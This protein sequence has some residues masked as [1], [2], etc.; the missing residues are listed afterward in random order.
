MNDDLCKNCGGTK[1]QHDPYAQAVGA[2]S[3]WSWSK[4]IDLPVVDCRK[5][6]PRERGKA[7]TT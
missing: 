1:E 7:I 5:F 3:I 2:K 6:E 4:G